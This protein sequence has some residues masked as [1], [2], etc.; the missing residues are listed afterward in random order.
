MSHS[1]R[2]TDVLIVGG[3][4]AG[5]CA[6]I[7]LTPLKVTLVTSRQV[8][9]G[10]SSEY[11]KGGI[12]ATMT[13]SDSTELHTQDTIIAGAGLSDP[14][15]TNEIV[16]EGSNSIKWLEQQTVQFDKDN[17]GALLLGKEG[18]HRHPRIV[19]IHGDQTGKY[20]TRS[21]ANR[22]LTSEHIKVIGHATVES[23]LTCTHGWV[24]GARIKHKHAYQDIAAGQ[25]IL[26][27]GGVG[28]L[29]RHTTNPVSS[30]GRGL[31]LA[32]RVGAR[33]VD[34]EFVQFHPTA[35]QAEADPLPLIT[36]ALRGAD[37][38]LVAEDGSSFMTD[39]DPRGD[40]APRDIVARALWRRQLKG[41]KCFLDG[42][43]F[44]QEKWQSQFP[45]AYGACQ[46]HK[47]NPNLELIPVT[48]AVHYHMGG[49]ETNIHGQTNV[50]GLWALGEAA[51]TGLHGA[52]RLAS[53]SL[54]EAVVVARK[55]ADAIKG[56]IRTPRAI[57]NDNQTA[58]DLASSGKFWPWLRQAMWRALG[59]ER[60]GTIMADWQTTLRCVRDE[61]ERR[62]QAEH[63]ALL[64]ADMITTAAL[65]RPE[66][67]GA[68]YRSD[69]PDPDPK[70]IGRLI[71]TV[72]SDT[73]VPCLDWA[74]LHSRNSAVA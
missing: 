63:D 56:N 21:L 11:A 40:L 9:R 42:R 49:I 46:H 61:Q 24:C 36:E 32:A 68:H 2:D 27:T 16:R 25:V 35:L 66:S 58:A 60:Q 64:V 74:P 41:H 71:V 12:A 69:I 26:S 72:N 28:G 5:M 53:N 34:M 29:F 13:P 17:T 45:S 20:M 55:C 62:S 1:Q 67:R 51:C 48:P 70:Q 59:V 22:I 7:A 30:V 33:L 14:E 23:L 18:A 4:L 15:V 52:N 47:L 73:Q 6:A 3:G 50:P 10:G 8:G 43:H 37:A 65:A 44:A 38:K 19:H 31:A 57:K 54:L 39:I